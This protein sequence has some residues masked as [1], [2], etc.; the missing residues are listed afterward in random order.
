MY[1]AVDLGTENAVLFTLMKEIIFEILEIKIQK[2]IGLVI[3][4]IILFR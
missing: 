2:R 1:N 4:S 3:C